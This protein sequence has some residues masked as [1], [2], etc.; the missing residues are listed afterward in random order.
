MEGI[1]IRSGQSVM[2]PEFTSIDWRKSP[3]YVIEAQVC[4]ITGWTSFQGLKDE[5]DYK[6]LYNLY[7]ALGKGNFD[8]NKAFKR[9]HGYR[10]IEPQSRHVKDMG[11]KDGALPEATRIVNLKNRLSELFNIR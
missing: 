7:E 4:G 10:E 11:V 1:K 8:L 5:T 6:T 3:M 2:G 9:R